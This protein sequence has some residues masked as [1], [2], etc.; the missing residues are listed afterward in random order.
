M[1]W[2]DPPTL[3]FPSPGFLRELVGSGQKLPLHR[4]LVYPRVGRNLP[5]RHG[6]IR[7]LLLRCVFRTL[8]HAAQQRQEMCKRRAGAEDTSP[9]QSG[10][11]DRIARARLVP[12][13]MP[14][15]ALPPVRSSPTRP[16]CPWTI[17][18]GLISSL[19]ST[20]SS[21][22]GA[23]ESDTRST[24]RVRKRPQALLMGGERVRCGVDTA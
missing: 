16:P 6:A 8:V 9:R 2:L 19:G 14:R 10:Q 17:E 20:A 23:V 21:S 4:G 18:C 7:F 11:I 12:V 15:S 5:C 22:S 13:W 1:P 3:Y 24:C